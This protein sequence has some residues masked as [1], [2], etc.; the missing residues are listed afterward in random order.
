MLISLLSAVTVGTGTLVAY[1][2]MECQVHKYDDGKV[3]T[4]PTCDSRGVKTYTC[5][6]CDKTKT[7][8]LDKLSHSYGPWTVTVEPTFDTEGVMERE[9]SLCHDTDSIS[10]DTV[11]VAYRIVIDSDDVDSKIVKV[12]K[13]GVY[14]LTEPVKAGYGF[15]KWVDSRGNDFAPSGVVSSNIGIKPVFELLDTTTVEELYERALA[16]ADYIRLAADIEVD[17]PIYVTGNTTIFS[18]KAVTISRAPTYNGDI[19]VVGQ[20]ALRNHGVLENRLATLNLGQ[21]SAS[22]DNTITIDGNK[23][24]MTVDVVGSAIYVVNSAT[25]NMYNN[26]VIT[27][28][29]KVG[30]ERTF[31]DEAYLS[32]PESVG[33][34]AVVMVN[35]TFNMYGG[36]I[37]NNESIAPSSEVSLYGGA[38]FNQSNVNVYGGLFENNTSSNSGGAIFNY[39]VT[40]I[41]GGSFIGNTAKKGGAIA[42]SGSLSSE[43]YIGKTVT[44]IDDTYSVVFKDNTATGNG[45]AILSSA[46]SPVVIYG[47]TLFEGNTAPSGRGGVVYTSGTLTIRHTKFVE[48]SARDNA[49]AIYHYYS[50]ED[51]EVR[52]LDVENCIFDGNSSGKGGAVSLNAATSVTTTGAYAI[53]KDCTFTNNE[54]IATVSGTELLNG[55]GAVLYST[56]SSVLEVYRCTF[57]SNTAGNMGGAV[58]VTSETTLVIHDSTF[59]NNTSYGKGGAL[60][61]Y[62]GSTLELLNS[63]FIGNRSTNDDGGAIYLSAVTTTIDDIT[64]DSN[65]AV[66]GGAMALF[67]KSDVTINSMSAT[68][69]SASNNG[70]VFYVKGSTLTL[71]KLDTTS[72]VAG[73][74]TDDSMQNIAT[75]YGGVIFAEA[76]ATINLDTVSMGYNKAVNGAV[77]YIDDCTLDILGASTFNN[78]TSTKYGGVLCINGKST[79]TMQGL[80]ADNNVSSNCGGFMYIHT[81]TATMDGATLTNNTSL[82]GGAIY[83][84]TNATLTIDSTSFTSNKTTSTGNGG[85][86]AVSKSKLVTVTDTDFTSNTA[87]LGGAIYVIGSTVNVGADSTFTTNSSTSYGGAIYATQTD[88]ENVD[89]R[90]KSTVTVTNAIFSKNSTVTGGGAIF[91]SAG[92]LD[93]NAATFSENETTSSSYGGG[94]LYTNASNVTTVEDVVFTANKS[95]NIGGAI[96]LYSG[97][98]FTAYSITATKNTA[99][100][101]GG[102]I[103]SSKSNI[104]ILTKQGKTSIFG[105]LTD[106]TLSNSAVNGGAIYIGQANTVVIDSTTFVGNTSSSNGAAIYATYSST[107]TITN[108]IFNSNKA[109][110]FGASMFIEESATATFK[111]TA[112]SSNT[113][114]YGAGVYALDATVNVEED[115]TFTA[116]EV[117]TTATSLYAGSGAILN[118]KDSTFTSNKASNYG[119]VAYVHASTATFDNITVTKNTAKRAALVY[120]SS[121]STVVIKN[122]TVYENIMSLSGGAVYASKAKKVEIIS[123]D[124]YSNTAPTGGA[125]YATGTTVTVTGGKI[126]DNT[127]TTGGGAIYATASAVVTVTGTEIKNNTAADGGAAYVIGSTL[128]IGTDT[129]LQGNT[130]TGSNGGGAI[131]SNETEAT[132]DTEAVPSTVSIQGATFTENS[133]KSGGAIFAIHTALTITDSSFTSNSATSGGAVYVYT[134]SSA[135]ISNTTFTTNTANGNGGALRVSTGVKDVSN[136]VLTAVTF[137]TNSTNSSSSGGAIYASG[138]SGLEIVSMTAKSN[139]AKYGGIIY[140]TSAGSAMTIHEMTVSGIY[141][142]KNSPYICANN[143]ACIVKVNMSKFI[144]LEHTGLAITDIIK[145]SIKA[146]NIT[147]ISLANDSTEEG[148]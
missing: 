44:S 62:N 61:V 22:V 127:S 106:N 72:I 58:N 97:S 9:C 56:S 52:V 36:M 83:S 19:F 70:A 94:A 29:K 48:N 103:Y 27:N 24:N 89:D 107:T 15:I 113:A 112:F 1:N 25:V 122:S 73:S 104:N 43:L 109:T 65:S 133:G 31:L 147:D 54:A 60:S 115:C 102:V 140:L 99:V 95:A 119:C 125:I 4:A 137:D 138:G 142:S 18:E 53:F 78:N 37:T 124:I 21:E 128:N 92:T 132:T 131:Y 13:D 87:K 101:S 71:E 5:E 11:D 3:T 146:E 51:L 7:V 64:F 88:E 66:D 117:T 135:T 12:A 39:K 2:N 130:S 16:G 93:L 143:A 45:G 26:V 30:N 85:A 129:V 32:Y 86:I 105:S 46:N 82:R 91:S 67:S 33:G 76:Y 96:A 100:A 59:T 42:L 145:G 68:K 139:T 144:D 148:A 47:D 69:N 17:R 38:V 84:S 8:E 90:K 114:K 98:T 80:S 40:T 49:G 55:N 74:L 77:I 23:S 63:Q 6:I 57:T 79:V 75:N 110:E 35:G 120:A 123:T 108:S 116:N 10:I 111:G 136:V 134:A 14:S 28:H 126:Y 34:A 81:A 41:L 141:T 50:N 118:V 20:D 121:N